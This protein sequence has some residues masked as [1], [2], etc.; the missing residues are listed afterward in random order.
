MMRN[1]MLP[2]ELIRKLWVSGKFPE[3]A[4]RTM[5]YRKATHPI[6]LIFWVPERN[7]LA[8]SFVLLGDA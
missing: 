6:L 7:R 8:V 4:W 3:T 1:N 5:N 2:V